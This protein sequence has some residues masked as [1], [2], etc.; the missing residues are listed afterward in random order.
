M[1]GSEPLVIPIKPGT[2]RSRLYSQRYKMLKILMK[3]VMWSLQRE[4]KWVNVRGAIN[5][6]L[7]RAIL[8]PLIASI[9]QV[10]THA[11]HVLNMMPVLSHPTA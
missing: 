7:L 8:V 5:Q 1:L 3:S 2:P 11:R 4:G 9:Y 6:W 10:F